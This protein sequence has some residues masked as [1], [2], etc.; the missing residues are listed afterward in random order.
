MYD[1]MRK[2]NPST[3]WWTPPSPRCRR[4]WGCCWRKN[5][6]KV[7]LQLEKC[8]RRRHKKFQENSSTITTHKNTPSL[9]SL[10]RWSCPPLYDRLNVFSRFKGAVW[11]DVR[12]DIK[13]PTLIIFS[14]PEI[15]CGAPD[16][17]PILVLQEV[18]RSLWMRCAWCQCLMCDM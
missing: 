5:L 2:K 18:H 13:P 3:N 6:G 9:G 4:P 14:P 11:G 1:M 16:G 7:V 10:N 15:T 12:G 17:H 8:Y